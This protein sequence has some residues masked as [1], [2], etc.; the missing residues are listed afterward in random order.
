MPVNYSHPVTCQ[1][2]RQ[3]R[4]Y[5]QLYHPGNIVGKRDNADYSIRDIQFSIGFYGY[6]FQ[7][8]GQEIVH[9][10]PDKNTP[11]FIPVERDIGYSL[12]AT[13]KFK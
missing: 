10:T 4:M 1:R 12:F 6:L 11:D 3:P 9:C 8:G 2:V 5:P 7:T 13:N